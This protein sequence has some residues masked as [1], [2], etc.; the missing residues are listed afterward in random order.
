[1]AFGLMV[2][3]QPALN[4]IPVMVL[5]IG[6]IV[7]VVNGITQFFTLTGQQV[8]I[9]GFV[10]FVLVALATFLTSVKDMP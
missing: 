2:D 9:V 8:S 5:L 3:P 1:M 7:V 6:F 4:L 10:A